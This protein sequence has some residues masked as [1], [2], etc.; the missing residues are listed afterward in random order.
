[1]KK[2][3]VEVATLVFAVAMTIWVTSCDTPTQ[4]TTKTET[5]KVVDFTTVEGVKSGIEGT[6]WTYT[7]PIDYTYMDP[8]NI[9]RWMKVEFKG[10]K[11]T[12]Y[13]AMPTDG[14]WTL[15]WTENYSV[16]EDR[17]IDTGEK[18]VRVSLAAK[19]YTYLVPKTGQF[20]YLGGRQVCEM[21][22]KDYSWD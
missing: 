15:K 18:Y 2:T 11:A 3:L 17:Y 12:L 1:M 7:E 4:Q 20:S 21:K 5:Q 19:Y 6:V 14:A 9:E 8:Y 22:Q 16:E 10:G 13:T